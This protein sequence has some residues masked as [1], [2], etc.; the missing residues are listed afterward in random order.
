MSAGPDARILPFWKGPPMTVSRSLLTLAL[1][2]LALAGCGDDAAAPGGPLPPS[3][4]APADAPFWK[5]D[6]APVSQTSEAG[7]GDLSFGFAGFGQPGPVQFSR[8][9][10][11]QTLPV[12]QPPGREAYGPAGPETWSNLL[13]LPK[14][15]QL[16]LRQVISSASTPGQPSSLCGDKPTTYLA[17]GVRPGLDHP[18]SVSIAAFA[19]AQPGPRG[20]ASTLCGVYDYALPG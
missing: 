13:T 10:V 4:I 19:G 5:A 3:T 17:I 14:D 15:V 12:R 9:L 16:E 20:E 6:F 11:L 2:A 7:P 18:G 8:G 1:G